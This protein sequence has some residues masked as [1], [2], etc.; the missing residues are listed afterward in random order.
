MG[1]Y[2]CIVTQA[3]DDYKYIIT[4]YISNQGLLMDSSQRMPAILSF[5]NA[6]EHGSLAAAARALGI[7]AAAVSKNLAGLERALGVRLMNRTTRSLQLTAEGSA[8]LERAR[9]AITAL[10]DAIDAVAAR[11]AEP[12]GRVRISTSSAFGRTYLLPMI[13]GLIRQFPAL[14]LEV[15]L[16][17][18]RVDLVKDGYDLALRGGVI[19]DSSLVSRRVCMLHTVLVASPDYLKARGVPKRIEDLAQ[20]ATIAVRFLSGHVSRWNFNAADGEIVE[21]EPQSPALTVSAPEAAVDAAV[22]GLGIAQA[23][24]HHAWSHLRDGRLK[25]LLAQHHHAG[26]RELVLQYPHR[27]LIA[28]RVRVTADYLLSELGKTEALHVPHDLLDKYAV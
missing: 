6:A 1:W 4:R 28:P 27:A 3:I 24:V 5:V 8:F 14:K 13:P 17:D 18:R 12:I 7:S 25:V 22:L 19:E 21:I 15:D 20:H 16:E 2:A 23:G 11:R 9:V 26:P 10:D